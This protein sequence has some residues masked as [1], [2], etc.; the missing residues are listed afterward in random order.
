MR[1][2]DRL[3]IFGHVICRLAAKL[4]VDT[5]S[6]TLFS[7][8]PPGYWAYKA[9]LNYQMYY[10]NTPWLAI[11]LINIVV[12]SSFM[13]MSSLHFTMFPAHKAL[14]ACLIPH[15]CN[16]YSSSKKDSNTTSHQCRQLECVHAPFYRGNG[17][18]FGDSLHR[19]SLCPPWLLPSCCYAMTSYA[20]VLFANVLFTTNM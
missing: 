20:N 3:P 15:R 14:P 13:E 10:S 19:F 2:T 17:G 8:H 11:L 7:Q 5:W 12:R 18:H 9:A 1:D 16:R 4:Y 6:C